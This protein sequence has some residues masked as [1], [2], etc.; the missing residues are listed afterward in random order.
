[1]SIQSIIDRLSEF[2]FVIAIDTSGSMGEPVK[3][4]SDVTRYQSVQESAIAMIRDAQA[5]DQDGLGLVLFGSKVESF[6][7]VT[8]DKAREIFA[9]RAPRGTTPLAEALDAC[10]ALAG[11]SDKKDVIIVFTDGV[12][13]D[14]AAAAQRII[15]QANSQASDDDCTV[16]FIQVGD[17]AAATAYLQSLDDDLKGA[18]FDIVDAKTVAE[19]NAFNSTA[20]LVV[21]AISG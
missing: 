16:L 5:I 2:D 15:Q 9:T 10:F 4:G 14:K 17:D 20:E 3:A 12:P 1:M 7:G 13:D 21:A 18:K 6:D 8:V 11:K 19:A